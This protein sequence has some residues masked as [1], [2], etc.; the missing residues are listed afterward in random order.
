MIDYDFL[1]Q[2]SDERLTDISQMIDEIL[3]DRTTNDYI[4]FGYEELRTALLTKFTVNQIECLK[5][6]ANLP[7]TKQQAYTKGWLSVIKALNK[8]GLPEG[9]GLFK[10]MV[11]LIVNSSMLGFPL[12]FDHIL[13][14][15]NSGIALLEEAFPGYRHDEYKM[16]ILRSVLNAQ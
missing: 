9:P 14:A 16:D 7:K 10:V 3:S 5:P 1:K 4:K 11:A 2:L 12:K 6:W 8:A 15:L 13:D